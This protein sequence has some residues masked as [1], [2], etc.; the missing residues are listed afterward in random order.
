V[1][2]QTPLL[3]GPAADGAASV[4]IPGAPAPSTLGPDDDDVVHLVNW[5]ESM[6]NRKQPNATVDHG[7]SHSIVCIMATQS[8]WSGKRVYW[9]AAREEIVDEL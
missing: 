7:F 2:K 5:L 1:Y 3:S 8:Y 9:D 4:H 6:R